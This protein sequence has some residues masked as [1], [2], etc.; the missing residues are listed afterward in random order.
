MN[1]PSSSR[2]ALA[3]A[4]AISIVFATVFADAVQIQLGRRFQDYSLFLSDMGAALVEGLFL[5]P[6]ALLVWRLKDA[7]RSLRW[8]TVVLGVRLAI[9]AVLQGWLAPG[10][11]ASLYASLWIF[12][13]LV[14]DVAFVVVMV[15]Y[16]NRQEEPFLPR[17]LLLL[18]AFLRIEFLSV[19]STLASVLDA[20]VPTLLL[21]G[22]V[23]VTNDLLFRPRTKAV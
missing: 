12:A 22:L 7:P 23:L 17:A 3:V 14:I 19:P 21:V 5:L 15:R 13:V 20:A 2:I 10:M 4:I 11:D 8:F 1:R 16:F 9:W 18:W 6:F